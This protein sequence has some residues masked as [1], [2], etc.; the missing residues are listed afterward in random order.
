MHVHNSE[1][2]MSIKRL[3][4]LL[5]LLAVSSSLH[6]QRFNKKAGAEYDGMRDTLWE[7]SLLLSQANSL[8]VSVEGGSSVDIDSELG[9]GFTIGWNWTPKWNF[10]WKFLLV[11]PDYSATIVPENPAVPPQTIN[12]SMDRYSNQLNATYHFLDGPLTPFVQAG[13]GWSKLDSN[14]PSAPPV[15]GCWWD[16]WWGYICN[17]TWST[18]DTSGF[19]YNVGLGLRWDVN[20][21]LFVRGSYNREFF[22]ADR[23]DLDFDTLSL[24]VGLMW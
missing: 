7:A 10:S 5:L 14:V 4:I 1:F 12:Y 6:A 8:D 16:P 21:A 3:I 19:S 17:T 13:V 15:T 18:Y 22:S 20:G 23:A 9:W 11:K 24:E 2:A